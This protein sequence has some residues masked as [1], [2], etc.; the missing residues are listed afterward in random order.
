MDWLFEEEE[1]YIG[2]ANAVGAPQ[3]WV[4][5][6]GRKV[7]T[8]P[9]RVS[10]GVHAIFDE[11]KALEVEQRKDKVGSQLAKVQQSQANTT[12]DMEGIQQD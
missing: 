6:K 12:Q 11:P 7:Q 3:Y 9:K 4:D 8:H 2:A 5:S 1:G 10:K